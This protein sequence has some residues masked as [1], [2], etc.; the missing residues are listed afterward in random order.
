MHFCVVPISENREPQAEMS[1]SEPWLHVG[2]AVLCC[3]WLLSCVGLSVTPWTVT[4]QAPLSMGI[5][6]V[7][8]LEWVAMPSSRGSSQARDM[9]VKNTNASPGPQTAR[10]FK[11]GALP[12]TL[13]H[14]RI[15]KDSQV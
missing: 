9:G 1:G 3:T 8:I 7:R 10:T 12:L 15:L 13:E 6:Q 11:D 14:P 5:L 4:C 2:V